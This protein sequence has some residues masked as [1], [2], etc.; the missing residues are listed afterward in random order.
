MKEELAEMDSND[1]DSVE[2]RISRQFSASNG[3][4]PIHCN[5]LVLFILGIMVVLCAVFIL[6]IPIYYFTLRSNIFIGFPT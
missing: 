1:T 2:A 5:L 4:C 3:R 6:Q